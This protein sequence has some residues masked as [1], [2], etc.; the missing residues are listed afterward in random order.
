MILTTLIVGF[1]IS[2]MVPNLYGALKVLFFILV[3]LL[4][5]DTILLFASKGKVEGHR[6]LSDKLSNGDENP[7]QLQL[8]N[9]YLFP[10]K[11]RVIDEIPFQFQKRDFLLETKLPSGAEKVF[12]Y[13]LRPTERGVYSFGSLN[14]FSVSPIGFLARKHAVGQSQEVP[15]YPSFLQLQKYDL[16][17]FTNRLHEYGLKKIRRIGHTME[18]EQIKDYVLGDDIRNINWKATAKRG[19]LMVNQYQDEKSQPVYSVI[20]KGRVMK[21][22]FNGLSLLDYAINA[23]LVISNIALK[24][25]DKAGMFSFS[26][27]IENRVVAERR[28]SQMNLI[29]ETLYNLE[30]NFIESDFSRL[31]VDVK[32]NLNQR[33]LLLLYTNFETMDA[34]HRQ[35][36][37]LLAMA[38][39]HLLVV[40]FFENTELNEFAHKK[41]ETVHQ[42]FEQTIAEK[43]IYEKKLIVNELRKH[44]IQTILTKPEDLTVNTINKYLEIKAR[45]LI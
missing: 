19:Q 4:I 32:R 1:V 38:K 33:S 40:I 3:L 14:I 18:F 20:D 16:L 27:K 26:D 15:V 41:A 43:F 39:Q 29:L 31:Y 37:Y 34:L 25:Q 22:P 13:Q 21:M 17:A 45:G 6:I 44:G 36:P 5:V 7:I 11:V 2:Y 35:L 28:S 9:G 30:T 10:V 12:H 8:M 23:T 42:I 24:K